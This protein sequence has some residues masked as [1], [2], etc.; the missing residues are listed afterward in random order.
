M[1]QE[2]RVLSGNYSTVIGNAVL[3]ANEH[4]RVW[5]F[6]SPPGEDAPIHKHQHSYFFLNLGEDTLEC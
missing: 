1:Q 5:S 3:L 6:I 2:D 4:V